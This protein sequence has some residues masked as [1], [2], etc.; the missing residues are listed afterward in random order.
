LPLP[1]YIEETQSLKLP[2]NYLEHGQVGWKADELWADEKALSESGKF[3]SAGR[4]VHRF[5]RSEAQPYPLLLQG[6]L[7]NEKNSLDTEKYR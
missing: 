2:R 7:G 1:L 4:P 3:H 5:Q 6:F